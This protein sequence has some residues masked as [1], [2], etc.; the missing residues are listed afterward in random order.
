MAAL[1]ASDTA[2]GSNTAGVSLSDVA[3]LPSEYTIDVVAEDD[4]TPVI[5][6]IRARFLELKDL[7]ALGFDIGIGDISVFESIRRNIQS[8][9]QSLRDIVSNGNVVS[10][11]NGLM[12]TLAYNAGKKLGSFV[13]I[14][15]SL[16]DNI[17]GGA[18]KA[19]KR[20]E[21]KIQ[22]WLV[23]MF[24]I[25]GQTDTILTDFQTAVAQI[26]TVFRSDEA[27]RIT[28]GIID[29][30]ASGFMGVTTLA[31]NLGSDVLS[32]IL[33]PIT[34]NADGFK[35]ALQATIEPLAEVMTTLSTDF[36][37]AWDSVNQVYTQHISPMFASITDGIS[38]IV[39]TLVA[40]YNAHLAP[41]LDSLAD[42]FS[43]V[44]SGT[45]QPLLAN[46]IGLFGDVSDL[47]TSV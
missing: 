35:E 43:K 10:S 32:L 14:G 23:G 41:V 27:K 28:A 6:R 11:F 19:L 26:L 39:G 2:S 15:S 17:T 37:D 24:S 9:G 38:E 42:K 36:A 22:D 5:D 25:A 47:V 31:G 45:I 21:T 29:I 1:S 18:A 12:D 44:W 13:S 4:V 8:I 16:I 20:N 33:Q 40:G 7:F 34:D 30:F 3:M 46:F